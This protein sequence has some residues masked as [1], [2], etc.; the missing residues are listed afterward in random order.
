ME[1]RIGR[2]NTRNGHFDHSLGNKEGKNDGDNNN[3]SNNTSRMTSRVLLDAVV[4]S[5][6]T[7]PAVTQHG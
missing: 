2:I 1:W 6:E 5:L 3:N 4:L 7:K